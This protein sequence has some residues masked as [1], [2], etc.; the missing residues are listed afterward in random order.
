[1][2]PIKM[3]NRYSSYLFLLFLLLFQ[4]VANADQ[5]KVTYYIPDAQ[6]SPV[7]AVDKDS[8]KVIW[9]KHYRPFGEEIEQDTASA[10]NHIGYTGHVHDRDAGLTYMGARYYDPVVGRFMSMDPAAVNPNDPA[11]FNR[12]AYGKNNPYKYTD[13]NGQFAIPLIIPI[14]E[15]AVTITT[16]DLAIGGAAAVVATIPGDAV[17]NEN[18]ND[19]AGDAPGLPDGLVGVQ[20]DKSGERGNRH[21]SGPLA[22][23]HGGT[24]EAHDDFDYLT[25][26]TGKQAPDNYPEG[27]RMGD[28]GIIIRPGINDKGARIDI[29]ANGDKPHETLHY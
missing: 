14:V 21:N 5:T 22:P 16:T 4:V 28:N 17:R 1:M 19:S 7:A 3:T 12:Y 29:P 23:E 18:G 10:S 13:P 26:G 11:S 2:H 9:R 15:W 27:T 24:G 25:G 8:G 6:G 20:D